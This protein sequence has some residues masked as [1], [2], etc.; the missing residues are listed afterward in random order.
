MSAD[1]IEDAIRE[2]QLELER[3]RMGSG[4]SL[5]SEA[6]EKKRRGAAPGARI[7][8]TD[9][10]LPYLFG[11]MGQVGREDGIL[12]IGGSRRCHCKSCCAWSWPRG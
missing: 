10:S 5:M 3:A 2:G 8:N 4:R 7:G 6:M 12:H 11:R 9:H 1:E